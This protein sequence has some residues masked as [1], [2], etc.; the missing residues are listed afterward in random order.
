MR[1][2][3]RSSGH[4]HAR[5]HEHG[6]PLRSPASHDSADCTNSPVNPMP[7]IVVHKSSSLDAVIAKIGQIGVLPVIR[8]ADL[9]QASRAVDAIREG[10]IP[11]VEITMTVP[12]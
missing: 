12:G 3:T 10:G 6:N 11:A 9:D 2:C 4:D 7:Q 1:R 5:G 8:A